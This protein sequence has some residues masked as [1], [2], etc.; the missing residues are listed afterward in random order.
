MAQTCKSPTLISLQNIPMQDK[1]KENPSPESPVIL[2][3][4]LMEEEYDPHAYGKQHNPTIFWGPILH[5]LK[6]IVG[7]GVLLLPYT[8]RS[9]GYAVAIFGT[10]FVCVLYIHVIHLLLEVEYQLCKKLKT[11]NLTYLGIVQGAFE[12]GPRFFRKLVPVGKFLVYF[13]NVF[14]KSLMNSVYLITIANNFKVVIDH[15]YETNTDVIT[16][17]TALMVPLIGLALIRELKFLVPLSMMTNAFSVLNLLLISIIPSSYD[18]TADMKAVNDI[19]QFPNFFAVLLGSFECTTLS[20]PVK[21]DMKNPKRFT[22]FFGVLNI[23]LSTTAIVYGVFGILGYA[24]YGD[25]LQTNIMLNLP[26]GEAIPLVI[27]SLHTLGMCTSFILFVY[28]SYDTIW[29][30]VFSGKR[31]KHPLVI[32]CAVRVTICILTYCFAVAI[33][34]FRLLLSLTNVIGILMDEGMPPILHM[35]L[36]V[37]KEGQSTRFYLTLLKDFVIVS[38]CFCLFMAALV[39]VVQNIIT[40]YY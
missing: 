24:K 36:L 17:M 40:F 23:A 32:E 21:N 28:I 4:S 14:N 30:N 9:V 35:L 13:H 39:D 8:F 3:K 26:P 18:G 16:I 10:I 33:P 11:P 1:E 25:R 15:Y 27:L 5:L 34:D 12:Q 22:T 37:K 7:T 2:E 31:V 38:I 20:L 29:N 6:Y 19:F